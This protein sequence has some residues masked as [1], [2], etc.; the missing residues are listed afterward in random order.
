MV[1]KIAVTISVKVYNQD[2]VFLHTLHFPFNLIHEKTGMLSYHLI[3]LLQCMHTER[4]VKNF[5][6]KVIRY[7]TTFKN[8]PQHKNISIKNN[9]NIKYQ[10]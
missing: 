8:D 1:I 5:L 2:I 6:S 3:I 10:L 7:A 4:V 9:I